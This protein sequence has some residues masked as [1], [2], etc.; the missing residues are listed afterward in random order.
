VKGFSISNQ[1]F[2]PAPGSEI[3]AR[4]FSP[5]EDHQGWLWAG[6]RNGLARWNGETGR[7]RPGWSRF[8]A[9]AEDARGN[10]WIGTEST[11]WI[12]SK[13]GNCSYQKRGGG[14]PGTTFPVL[15]DRDGACG[16]EPPV[17]AG[18]L[19]KG[20]WAPIP[21]DDGLASNN[22]I[23][24]SKTT[25]DI[26]GLVPIGLMRIQKKSLKTC[27]W[28]RETSFRAGLVETDRT[29]ERECS[30]VH[31]R[32]GSHL[33]GYYGFPPPKVGVSDRE[34]Q[35]QSPAA[36][37]MMILLVEGRSKKQTGL[38]RPGV[39]PS[40]S[41][42]SRNGNALNGLEFS[43]PREWVQIS[44]GRHETAWTEAGDTR[45]AYYNKVPPGNFVS[46]HRRQ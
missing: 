39:S 24:S 12:F 31:T 9:V 6:T 14:L 30:A 3:L 38:V 21:A 16:L 44:F 19:Y 5:V 28:N 26:Y 33:D 43:A 25:A 41:A 10:L 35:A 1:S 15:L 4:K 37:V 18:P 23:T 17:T 27:R 8:R 34:P 29:A 11:G 13:P 40:R 46:R 7:F 36:V 2:Q 42:P 22:I 32:C 45:V 20:K